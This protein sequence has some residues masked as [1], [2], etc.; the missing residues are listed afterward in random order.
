VGKGRG[1][2]PCC[3]DAKGKGGGKSN[4]SCKRGGSSRSLDERIKEG[5][6]DVFILEKGEKGRGGS[7]LFFRPLRERHETD[8]NP[9]VEGLKKEK[10]RQGDLFLKVPERKRARKVPFARKGKK[11][12][13]VKV[14]C[15]W[16]VKLLRGAKY[17]HRRKG[18]KSV[19]YFPA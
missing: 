8:S 15:G 3:C 16:V 11:R 6:G 4:L 10:A 12:R 5:K 14:S 1:H 17:R 7:F 9:R 19:L 13:T 18:R 2:D